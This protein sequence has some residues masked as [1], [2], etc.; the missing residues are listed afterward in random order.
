MNLAMSYDAKT[1]LALIANLRNLAD[2]I[3]LNG[4]GV[5]VGGTLSINVENDLIHSESERG[6]YQAHVRAVDI[7]VEANLRLRGRMKSPMNGLKPTRAEDGFIVRWDG[8]PPRAPKRGEYYLAGWN[9]ENDPGY[10]R[11]ATR[12]LKR[13]YFIYEECT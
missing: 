5:I 1:A 12:N 4:P 8:K 2:H 3:E 9:V 10:V 13:A 6:H 7:T 11:Q